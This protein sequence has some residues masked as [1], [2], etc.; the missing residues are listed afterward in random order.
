VSSP[1]HAPPP[2][3]T[4]CL[5]RRWFFS[6]AAALLIACSS[7]R[8]VNSA[9]VRL[10]AGHW[11]T[12][13]TGAL[14][15]EGAEADLCLLLPP[16]YGFAYDAPAIGNCDGKRI[17]LR[18][19]LAT[20]DGAIVEVGEPAMISGGAKS[21]CFLLRKPAPR[22]YRGLE[23]IASDTITLERVQWWRATGWRHLERRGES[24]RSARNPL[25]P[26]TRADRQSCRSALVIPGRV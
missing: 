16:G 12:I 26:M 10:E 17:D 2:S 5:R 15:V 9:P 8:V 3:C 24:G 6:V 19:R 18:A 22:G 7:A 11:Q 4:G 23:L 20:F 14:T 13:P 21:V 25:T 1:K